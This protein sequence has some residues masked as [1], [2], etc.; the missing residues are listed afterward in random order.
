M[1]ALSIPFAKDLL[2]LTLYVD[3]N[4]CRRY[5]EPVDFSL[6]LCP[7]PFPSTTVQQS[8]VLLTLIAHDKRIATSNG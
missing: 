5:T 4:S 2:T 3:Y 6:Q 1:Q 7:F 8:F